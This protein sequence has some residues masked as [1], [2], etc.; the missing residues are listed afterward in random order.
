MNDLERKR[1]RGGSLTHT[2]YERMRS[3]VLSGLIRP[4]QK[5]K[6]QEL[7]EQMEANQGA[8]RE[9]LSRLASE[10]L[11]AAEPQ[12]GFRVR[13]ISRAELLDLT[14]VRIGIESQCLTR[15]LKMGDLRWES[16]V[17]AAYHELSKTPE[18]ARDPDTPAPRLRMNESWSESHGRYHEALTSACDSPWLMRLRAQ[19]F[20]QAE[21]YRRLSVPLDNENRDV[22]AE[23][24]AIMEAAIA[25]DDKRACELVTDHFN[26]TA[27]TLLKALEFDEDIDDSHRPGMLRQSR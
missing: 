21:R 27:E 12:K 19:L 18:K 17:M 10:G 13:P 16:G 23:H 8:V 11:V 9:A 22:N 5:L 7:V 2:V 25:R 14:Q 6:I 4:G 15:A 1:N 20:A 26:T 3:Q 24:R